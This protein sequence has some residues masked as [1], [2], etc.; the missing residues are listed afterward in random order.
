M[1]TI[2]PISSHPIQPVRHIAL[3]ELNRPKIDLSWPS[4]TLYELRWIKMVYVSLDDL[5][6]S[7]DTKESWPL[8]E[9][10]CHLLRLFHPK[11]WCRTFLTPPPSDANSKGLNES[12][13]IW[14]EALKLVAKNLSHAKLWLWSPH[15]HST[16]SCQLS[17]NKSWERWKISST[18]LSKHLKGQLGPCVGRT[19]LNSSRAR[20]NK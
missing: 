16:G 9:H 5:V 18:I 19:F 15:H 12:T 14:L 8:F 17:T 10:Q 4:M 20:T 3:N 7:S 11:L 6:L 1:I 2:H 13:N